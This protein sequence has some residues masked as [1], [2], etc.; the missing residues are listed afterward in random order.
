MSLERLRKKHPDPTKLGFLIM[1]FTDGKP[2]KNIVGVIKRTAEK[3][4]L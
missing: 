2:F 3:H 4:G 1:R